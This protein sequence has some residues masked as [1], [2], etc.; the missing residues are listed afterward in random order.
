M[1]VW[2]IACTCWVE[3]IHFHFPPFR[4]GCVWVLAVSEMDGA[5]YQ[6]MCVDY[7]PLLFL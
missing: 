7:E 2:T 1:Q 3:R 5:H 6:H 4:V